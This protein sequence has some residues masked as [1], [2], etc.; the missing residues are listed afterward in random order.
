[1]N[2]PTGYVDYCV[3]ILFGECLTT[4]S[5]VAEY[6]NDPSSFGGLKITSGKQALLVAASSQDTGEVQNI[7]SVEQNSNFIEV[8]HLTHLVGNYLDIDNWTLDNFLVSAY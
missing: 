4:A 2:I 6:F 8:Y 7:F 3:V 5:S 1:M